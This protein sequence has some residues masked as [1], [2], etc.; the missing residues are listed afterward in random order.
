MSRELRAAMRR[1]PAGKR[2]TSH[3]GATIHQLFPVPSMT[4]ATA[5]TITEKG[6]DN[7]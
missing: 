3:T 7:D 2:L 6:H 5:E 4:T 1:H